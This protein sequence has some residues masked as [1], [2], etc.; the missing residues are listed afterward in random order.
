MPTTATAYIATF[1]NTPLFHYWVTTNSSLKGFVGGFF[2]NMWESIC[3]LSF[4]FDAY[5]VLDSCVKFEIVSQLP[6]EMTVSE[7]ELGTELRSCNL[8]HFLKKNFGIVSS[9]SICE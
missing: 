3:A 5:V 2:W 9:F 4:D 1:V 8:G 7:S 6:D